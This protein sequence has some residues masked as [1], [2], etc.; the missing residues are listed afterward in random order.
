[1]FHYGTLLFELIADY[2]AIKLRRRDFDEG[3]NNFTV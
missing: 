3:K 1:M 2:D